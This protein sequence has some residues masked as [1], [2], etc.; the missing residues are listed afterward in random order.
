M[1]SNRYVFFAVL[2][3]VA[4]VCG[5][6]FDERLVLICVLITLLWIGCELHSIDGE[7]HEL[8][9][10]VAFNLVVIRRTIFSTKDEAGPLQMRVVIVPAPA[11]REP[12]PAQ[13][14]NQHICPDCKGALEIDEVEVG[15]IACCE[16]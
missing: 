1:L 8:G 15:E 7:L 16:E 9:Y 12:S 14:D 10:F 3:A 11:Q 6:F 2:A 13:H 5:L 4:A